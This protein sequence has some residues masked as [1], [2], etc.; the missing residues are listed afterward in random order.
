MMQDMM[1]KFTG[2]PQ[3]AGGGS[4]DAPREED[5]REEAQ[6]A[7]SISEDTA[8]LL[9]RAMI[10]AAYADGSLSTDERQRIMGHIEEAGGDAEDRAVMEREIV[11]PKSLDELLSQVKDEETAKEFYMASRAAVDGGTAANHA[12]LADMQKRLGLSD[13]QAAEVEEL[14]F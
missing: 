2:G 7:E 14:A 4:A 6:A 5:L 1:D 12:Y 13:E 3:Q 9:I 10:T 8:L 11:N